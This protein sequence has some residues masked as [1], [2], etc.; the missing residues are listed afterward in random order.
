VILAE[1]RPD[2][3]LI[4][5]PCDASH[6]IDTLLDAQTRLPVALYSYRKFGR[7]ERGQGIFFPMCSYSP[8]FIAL[9][10][11]RR[12]GAEVSFMDLPGWLLTPP[13]RTESLAN[14]YA[15]QE[16][17]HHAYIEVLCRR[18]RTRDFDELWD[19]L[20]E[21]RPP[22]LP[23][24]SFFSSVA[25][26]CLA[27]RNFSDVD[28]FT[29]RREEHMA[30][31]VQESLRLG[32]RV[33][34][35]VG[36][37][38]RQG[39]RDLLTRPLPRP[40]LPKLSKSDE[41]GLYVIPYGYEQLSR[42]TGYQS[43]M[44]APAFY[45]AL[46]SAD[47]W[48]QP[49]QTEL[50]VRLAQS[51]R[52]AGEIVSTADVIAAGTS[53]TGLCQLRQHDRPTLHDVRDAVRSTWIKGSQHD[54]GGQLEQA[55]ASALMGQRV[56]HVPSHAGRPPILD[57]LYRHMQAFGWMKRSSGPPT[58][59]RRISL[60]IYRDVSHRRRS[61]FLH[62]LAEL[63]VP[64]A[65]CDAGP[66]FVTG[67]DTKRVREIWTLRWKPEVDAKLLEGAIF[68][69]T[70]AEAAAHHLLDRARSNPHLQSKEAVKLLIASLLMDLA[71]EA[72]AFL[73]LVRD[74]L[75]QEGC[76]AEAAHA[77]VRLVHLVR[78]RTILGAQRHPAI[79]ELLAIAYRR[80]I[81]LIDSLPGLPT[82]ATDPDPASVAVDPVEEAV[83]GLVLLRHAVL[84]RDDDALDGQLFL[85]AIERVRERLVDHYRLRG[86]ADGILGHA[87]RIDSVGVR[88]SLSNILA[89][90]RR[91]G[92]A[93]F[94]DYLRGLLAVHRH[95][96]TLDP[97]FFRDVHQAIMS[98]DESD[99]RE[100]L[101]TL[102]MAFLS[103]TPTE[104]A[105]L[106]QRL[107]N[108]DARQAPADVEP[109]CNP[110]VEAAVRA[111]LDEWKG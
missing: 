11:G 73:P 19:S 37:Y 2:V 46:W 30:Y 88:Q 102:R 93:D 69:S 49:A 1:V 53:L 95:A 78:Y 26:Y 84:A 100:T 85:D 67:Q 104:L 12:L 18:T 97:E 90:T 20:F 64:L 48:S 62:R 68:G 109:P 74:A 33:V 50:I 45:E 54:T 57:D 13:E 17:R 65:R 98:L 36:G 99:F 42:W 25:A 92:S 22:T 66:D 3:V 101:P 87:R 28:E 9:Q 89:G 61:A 76:F 5:G 75:E 83:A 21:S 15:D 10:E 77:L 14:A 72:D 16:L 111:V 23:S 27:A 60:N 31:R 81:W 43:G 6:L 80:S 79:I 106:V 34:A 82:A 24:D 108:V 55:V 58:Q 59:P 71:R 91:P 51:A 44:P 96:L 52:K 38:H 8:E 105:Q 56:G 35:I 32:Q 63:D 110:A 103:F 86:A 70:I 47:R 4:E 41:C 94:G 40:M 107:G 39:I 29:Q 7:D